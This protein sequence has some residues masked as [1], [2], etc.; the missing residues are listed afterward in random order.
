MRTFTRLPRGAIHLSDTMCKRH[1]I[2]FTRMRTDDT[3]ENR[4]AIPTVIHIWRR[5]LLERTI[6]SLLADGSCSWYLLCQQTNTDY[7]S[8]Y[9]F[10]IYYFSYCIT[11]SHVHNRQYSHGRFGWVICGWWIRRQMCYICRRFMS[12]YYLTRIGLQA[13]AHVVDSMSVHSNVLT[14]IPMSHRWDIRAIMR[15]H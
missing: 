8:L 11:R 5:C 10:G 12:S 9:I 3:Q 14:C 6:G 1:Q 7:V 4:S 13:G 15:Y 2:P